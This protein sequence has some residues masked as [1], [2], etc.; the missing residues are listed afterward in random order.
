MLL[1]DAGLTLPV[2]AGTFT[3]NGHAITVDPN[4]MTWAQVN[5]AIQA[6]TSNAASLTFGNNRVSLVSPGN[7]MQIGASTDTSNFL[8]AAHLLGAAQ[9]ASGVHPAGDAYLTPPVC[10]A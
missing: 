1:K 9:V 8:S 5:S 3:I 7:P 6:A 10:N 4:T 2:T